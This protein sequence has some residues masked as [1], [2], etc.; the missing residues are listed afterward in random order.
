MRKQLLSF[1]IFI[2]VIFISCKAIILKSYGIKNPDIENEHSIIKNAIKYNVDTTNF[3]TVS[4]SN[5]LKT[6]KNS[7]G[8]PNGAIYDSKGNY[9]EYRKFDTSCNAGLFDFIPKLKLDTIFKMPLKDKLQ[10]E[11]EKFRSLKGEKIE[12]NLTKGID[13][14]ILLYSSVW[15]G[16]LNKDHIQV[17]EDLARNNKNCKIKIINVVLDLQ[18]YW[19]EKERNSIISKMGK[20]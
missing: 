5:F 4:S 12:T 17:W 14:Y 10:T 18:Q 16:K 8:I 19:D 3:V 1:L 7:D 6:F 20:K 11:L 15:T 2:T 13:F 9:I